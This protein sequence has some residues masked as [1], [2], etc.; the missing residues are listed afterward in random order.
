MKQ[1]EVWLIKA[2]NDL[3]S[4]K[5]LLD[6]DD[7]ILDTAI[8]HTQQCAEK[9]LKAYLSFQQKPI[10]KIHNLGALID[11]CSGCDKDFIALLEDAEELN[12]YDAAFRYPDLIL[13]P[14]KKDVSDAIEKS[15]KILSF[16]KHKI[17]HLCLE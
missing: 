4:A 3:K 13:E 8:Y 16:V 15:E 7:P 6:G 1:H 2:G 17:R 9:A 5:K 10:Q 12:P 11:L 14:D